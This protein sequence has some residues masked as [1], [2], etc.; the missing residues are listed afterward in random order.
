[1]MCW[2]CVTITTK[3]RQQFQNRKHGAPEGPCRYCGQTATL[4][5]HVI[6]LARG[7]T[8]DFRNIAL[9]CKRCNRTKGT[10]LVPFQIRMQPS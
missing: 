9:A 10:N 7:G 1:M 2:T 5:D 3:L 6:P 8:N 4:R